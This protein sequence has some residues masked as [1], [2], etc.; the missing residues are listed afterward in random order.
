M[1]QASA[2]SIEN[3]F[4]KGLITEASGL[5]YP[6]NSCTDTENCIFSLL[7]EAFRRFGFDTEHLGSVNTINRKN[8]VTTTY[9]W[10]D[11]GGDGT[12]TFIVY[13]NG[14]TLYFYNTTTN[15]TVSA[16]LH[17]TTITLS[18][19]SPSG[20]PAPDTNEC[21]FSNGNGFLFVTH[22]NLEPFYVQYTPATNTIVS[23]QINI[24]IRDTIGEKTD[25]NYN[26]TTRPT[27]LS[28]AHKYNL[29]NQGWTDDY[30]TQWTSQKITPT[31]YTITNGSNQITGFDIRL[32]SQIMIG[33]S[34]TNDSGVTI[35]ANTVVSSINYLLTNTTASSN[36]ATVNMNNNAT[37]NDT[38]AGGL[39]LH[40]TMAVQPGNGDVWWHYLGDSSGLSGAAPDMFTIGAVKQSTVSNTFAPKGHFIGSPW[41]F[42]R[43]ALSGLSGLT[44][45][46]CGTVR[47]STTAFYAGRVWFAGTQFLG[48]NANLYF[49]QILD[50]IS[51]AGNCYQQ[52]DP[53]D[54]NLFDLLPSDGGVISIH[55]C[56]TIHKLMQVG[57]N[58][59]IFASNGVWEISGNQG[60]GFVANDYSINKISS[61][62]TL[63]HRSFVDVLGLPLWWNS[64]GIY[65][66]QPSQRGAIIEPLTIT[67][68]Q[69]FLN[70]IPAASKKYVKGAYDPLTKIVQ[71]VF[72]STDA[73]SLE[74][75]YEYDGILNLNTITGAFYPWFIDASSTIIN[76]V[77]IVENAGGS[78]IEVQI[79]D[80]ALNNVVD[81]AGNNVVHYRNATPPI[82]TGFKYLC[83]KNTGGTNYNV[84]FA[85]NN[86]TTYVDWPQDTNQ[87]YT[88]YFI[89]GYQI[90]GEANRNFQSNYVTLYSSSETTQQV[91]FQGIFNWALLPDAGVFGN[92][93]PVQFTPQLSTFS[94]TNY[95]FQG[96]RLLVRGRGKA[97]Q[98]KITSY[99]GQPF[100]I[101][102]WSVWTTINQ[103][104]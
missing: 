57:N 49:S 41:N 70:D 5:N 42:D 104:I 102:G 81:L 55:G 24:Q 88:S 67:T 93:Q 8:V 25:V 64:D 30:L 98:F 27:G 63:S 74:Q 36:T 66:V 33:M 65:S 53:T 100:N 73:S 56:G 80:N 22:P 43:N 58:L 62:P 39:R 69:T 19:Y 52:E 34:V 60:I 3:N 87:D 86:V 97:V 83:S 44:I 16:G 75:N 40:F 28:N 79:I 17:A 15:A 23:T 32:A 77:Q 26:N 2:T 103:G 78:V 95:A 38:Q 85:D 90:R 94:N 68:I 46:S 72:R 7:G 61:V 51:K 9:L 18:T 45:T 21:Q 71:W 89:S 84:T 35:P 101:I 82:S 96:K 10:K 29:Y 59:F 31:T 12:T 76:D 11:A 48:Y 4:S 99:P 1:P 37:S 20:A 54:Q 14:G 91:Y 92:P 6:E 13:Q 50:D 47:P